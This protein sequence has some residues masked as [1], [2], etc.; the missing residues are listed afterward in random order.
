MGGGGR[1]GAGEEV[2]GVVGGVGGGGEGAGG[3]GAA[4]ERRSEGG[5][6]VASAFALHGRVGDDGAAEFGGGGVDG[7]EG[8]DVEEE[9]GVVVEEVFDAA[10]GEGVVGVGEVG[11]LLHR[12][13]A[14]DVGEDALHG[15][16]PVLVHE[17]LRPDSEEG[18]LPGFDGRWGR[19]GGEELDVEGVEVVDGD[20]AFA[21]VVQVFHQDFAET[22]DL[23]AVSLG[24]VRGEEVGLL[25]KTP[26]E[27]SELLNDGLVGTEGLI[28]G[29]DEAEVED[30]FIAVVVGRFD[31]DGIAEDSV[32]FFADLDE[33]SAELLP[34]YYE[35]GDIWEIDKCLCIGGCGRDD[36]V[37]WHLMDDFGTWQSVSWRCMRR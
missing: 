30:E 3:A 13:D 35:K 34:W 29:E 2:V 14:V 37:L 1:D 25:F 33:I 8:E 10:F 6:D 16:V 9:E 11:D 27:G 32:A 20:H 19:V 17:R 23:A 7:G 24:R 15:Q 21:V 26:H 4:G 22:V 31:A 36:R 18:H 5:V 12:A 28:L